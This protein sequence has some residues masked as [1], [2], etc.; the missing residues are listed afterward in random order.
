MMNIR[1][2]GGKHV[3]I[4]ICILYITLYHRILVAGNLL[5][6]GFF[7]VACIGNVNN[8]YA[9]IYLE[10]KNKIVLDMNLPVFVNG[11]DALPFTAENTCSTIIEYCAKLICCCLYNRYI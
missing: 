4:H 5:K 6:G 7:G 1:D 8:R 11:S 10:Q 3:R 2:V 9:L